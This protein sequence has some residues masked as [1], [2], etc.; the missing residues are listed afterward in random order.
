[1]GV[2]KEP[3]ASRNQLILMPQSLDEMVGSEEP[4][5]LLS[6]VMDRLDYGVLESSYPG[7]G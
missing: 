4:V 5:R 2:F 3:T 7:G 1:M 6:E